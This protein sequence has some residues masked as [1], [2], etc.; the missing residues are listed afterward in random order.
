[1]RVYL[2]SDHAGFELKVH[3]ANHLAKQGYEVVDIGPHAYDPEDD[4]PAF[5][6]HAG[7]RVVADPGSLGVVIGGSGNGEQIAANKVAGVRAALAW[8]VETAQLGRQHNDANVVAVGARQHTLDEA[9]AIV[10]AFLTTSFSG[11]ERH[12]RRIAQVAEYERTRQLP[13][14]P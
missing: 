1:M 5:C 7:T 6:L 14:L 3:L 13:E 4:Y 10:D 11:S 12:A 9:A 8:S 2:G